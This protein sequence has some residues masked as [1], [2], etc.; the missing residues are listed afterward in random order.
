M[1]NRIPEKTKTKEF[2][3][4]KNKKPRNFLKETEKRAYTIANVKPVD[5]SVRANSLKYEI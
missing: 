5:N 2:T 4:S 3:V 1:G